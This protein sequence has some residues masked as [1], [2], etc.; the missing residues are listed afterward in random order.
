M[1]R[2]KL[3]TIDQIR[4][5]STPIFQKYEFINKAYLFGSYAKNIATTNSDIDIVVKL[6]DDVGMRLYGLY[7]DFENI[8]NKKID[9]LTENEIMEIMPKV[10]K[11]DRILIYEK[12]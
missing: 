5:F 7:Y 2:G 3:L 11:R 10:Y 12:C 1:M 4:T 8:F 9:L 6:D